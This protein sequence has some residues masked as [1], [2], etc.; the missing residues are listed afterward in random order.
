VFFDKINKVRTSGIIPLTQLNINSSLLHNCHRYEATKARHFRKL[1]KE[2]KFPA[3]SVF[4][5]VGSGMGRAMLLAS[6][7]NFKRIVGIE[8]SSYLCEIAK[9]NL[10]TYRYSKCRHA[11]FEIFNLNI[12]EYTFKGDENVFF[13]FN[14]FKDEIVDKFLKL[15]KDSLK[16]F[17]RKIWIIYQKP[18]FSYPLDTCCFLVKRKE[19]KYA[20]MKNYIYSNC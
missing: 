2:L 10:K 13:L 8:I 20:G 4:V 17:P 14:P 6:Y 15:I 19:F 9:S 16:K 3:N 5:D 11:N 1:M 18:D 7:F 12:L